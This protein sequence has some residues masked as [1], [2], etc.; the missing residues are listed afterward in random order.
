MFQSFLCILV[1]CSFQCILVQRS[2]H[3]SFQ[4]IL[5]QYPEWDERQQNIRCC[6]YTEEYGSIE[7]RLHALRIIQ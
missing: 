6:P 7:T 2:F 5:V 4:Y 3:C 1:H